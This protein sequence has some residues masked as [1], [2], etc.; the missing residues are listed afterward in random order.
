VIELE[1]SLGIKTRIIEKMADIDSA[2]SRWIAII[3][4]F[5]IIFAVALIIFISPAS[6]L[7]T[8]T[9]QNETV[10]IDGIQTQRIDAVA[11]PGMYTMTI[12][13]KMDNSPGLENNW[14]YVYLYK[15]EAPP[16]DST[17]IG[18]DLREYLKDKAFLAQKLTAGE[19]D[20]EWIIPWTDSGSTTFHMVMY[21][22]ANPD[23]QYQSS[24]SFVKVE[25][26]YEPTLPLVPITFLFV[27]AVVP[28][29]IIRIYVLNQ[30]KKELRIQ[31]SLD[32]ENLSNEDRVRL[33]IPL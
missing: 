1:T 24:E 32:L 19:N 10:E 17:L 31:L 15:D 11:V 13:V 28:L 22:P 9:I 3:I 27:L 33:G 4:F 12:K 30:K 8:T 2:K 29:G 21:N 5:G 6:E 23:N 16:I 25:S 7:G 18:D 14:M 26:F 20:V